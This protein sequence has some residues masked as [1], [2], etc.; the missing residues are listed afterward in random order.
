MLKKRSTF[1]LSE[2]I[3]LKI[4]KLLWQVKLADITQTHIFTY[5]ELVN[6]AFFANLAP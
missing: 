5:S 4:Q 6:Q 2:K 1:I 3:L